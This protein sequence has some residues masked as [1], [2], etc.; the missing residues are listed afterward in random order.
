MQCHYLQSETICLCRNEHN[1]LKTLLKTVWSKNK[2]TA[3]FKQVNRHDEAGY[4]VHK[5]AFCDTI[6]QGISKGTVKT[7][8][9]MSVMTCCCAI[10]RDPKS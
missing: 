3:A 5:I 6:A 1:A 10:K 8:V 7:S 2:K 9:Y 4:F